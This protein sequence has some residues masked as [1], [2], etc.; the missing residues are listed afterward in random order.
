MLITDPI[1]LTE[2]G[3]G[4]IRELH[5]AQVATLITRP[6]LVRLSPAAG[7][8]WRIAGNQ[9]VGLIRLGR[10]EGAVELHIRPK[11]DI[12]RLLFLLTYASGD[13]WHDR[14]VTA[15]AAD[16]LLSAVADAYARAARRTL[17]SGVLHGYR[18][19]DE[20]LPVVRGRIRTADQM[21]RTGLPLPVAVRYD[22]FTADIAENRI[23]L[24][25]LHRL[26]LLPGVTTS[27]RHVMRHLAGRLSGVATLRPGAPL[28]TWSQTR[29]NARYV[30]AL[31][32]AE[33]VLTDRS[34]TPQGAAS[35]VSDGFVLDLPGVFENFLATAL[36]EALTAHQVRCAAQES[37]HRLD[38]GARIRIRPD[39]VL[40]RAGSALTVLDAK[41]R[42]LG[43]APPATEHMYQ[44]VSYCTALG[45]AHG[46][47]VYAA[48]QGSPPTP[49][50]IRDAGITVSAHALDL[51]RT[52]AEILTSV[53]NLA[54]HVTAAVNLQ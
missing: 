44:L 54:Q 9:K 21:R 17:E 20:D 19:T 40:Y 46:H 48:G 11:L 39:L 6:D 12:S 26:E 33:L 14:P 7:G 32:L 53:A 38:L 41:Y 31:R 8:R 47:L 1:R 2:T 24:A 28:P 45:L 35:V 22:D 13:P 43:T 3:P 34:L 25:A 51:S 16:D 18:T 15:S 27:T 50:T 29:L 4:V 30:P 10:G 5:P 37:H 36:G 52:P 23:L 49:Y 42:D